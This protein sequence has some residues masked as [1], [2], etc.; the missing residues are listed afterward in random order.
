[1][2]SL[3]ESIVVQRS[4]TGWT[5]GR[6][7]SVVVQCGEGGTVA[8]GPDGRR[9]RKRNLVVGMFGGPRWAVK[10]KSFIVVRSGSIDCERVLTA[11]SMICL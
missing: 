5:G 4:I 9:C 11:A 3:S 6:T 8:R 2:K 1:M 7:A 10:V